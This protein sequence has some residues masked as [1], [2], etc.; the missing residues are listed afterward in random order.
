MLGRRYA[1]L[2]MKLARE[3]T[4]PAEVARLQMMA[5]ICSRVP[6]YPARTFFEAVQSLWFAHLL[7]CAED[8][9]NANSLGR[10]DQIL[11]PYYKADIT[12][13]RLSWNEAIEIMEELA[14][15]LYLDYDVQAI[16]L[17]GVDAQGNDAVNDLSYIILDATSHVDL[18]RDLSVRLTPTTPEPFVTRCAELIA[19]GGGIPFL[20]NDECF[21]PALV[22][23]GITLEDARNYSPIGCVELTIPGKASPHA[24]SSWFNSTKCLELALFDGKDPLTG[25]Q[26]GPHTGTLADLPSYDTLIAAYQ[27][28]VAYFV[29][30]M[31]YFTNRGEIAQRERGPLPC[32][33][34]LTDDCIA[35]GRDITNGGPIYNYHSICLLGTAN[36]AD[37]LA[38]VKRLIF[39]DRKIDPS[40]LLTTLAD[41]F[42]GNESLRQ[43]LLTQVAKYGNDQDD[44]D[45]IARE[46]DEH[47]IT[48]MDQ[49][50]T[51]LHGRYFVHL[52]SFYCN[53]NFGKLLGATPDGRMSGEP[54]AYSLS[55]QQGRDSSGVTAMLH[56]LA[57]MPHQRAA[58]GSACIVELDP[59]VIS[60]EHGVQRLAQLIRAAFAMGVGQLQWNITTAERLK[61]AQDDPEHYGNIPVRVAGYS[62]MFK[63]IPPELQ[64]HIIARTKHKS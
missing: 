61:Q 34:V 30:E 29:R 31:V 6:A 16:T 62:Q 54:I 11:Y 1:E 51:P 5:E 64:N 59:K 50:T 13:D 40:D 27:Q 43:V 10:L 18:I 55:A 41:N 33:S 15:K 7:T 9:I 53:I 58:G 36:T 12:A 38:A 26:L 3:A 56:S 52:F 37:S 23:H 21:I 8:G 32:F 60:D 46:I 17:A 44:V 63:L 20:F 47:F 22:N 19:R 28:Q 2:A 14:C 25:K 24:V 39:D 48:L 49:Y 35:R 4:D 42:S 45:Q 57:K